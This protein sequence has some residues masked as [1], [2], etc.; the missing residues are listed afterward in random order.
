MVH[1]GLLLLIIIMDIKKLR[2][3]IIDQL[4]ESTVCG[5]KISLSILKF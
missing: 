3:E 4:T 2:S 5:V 1:L